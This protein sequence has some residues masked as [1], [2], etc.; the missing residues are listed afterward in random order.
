MSK[1][2]TFGQSQKKA[3]PVSRSG[4]GT[5]GSDGSELDLLAGLAPLLELRDGGEQ[6]IGR[7]VDGSLER[8]LNDA[9]DETD[10]DDLHGDVVGDAEQGAGHG[11]EQQ[12]AARNAGRAARAERRHDRQDDRDGQLHGDAERVHRGERHDRDRD[13]SAG[14]VDGRAE[15]DGHGVELLIQTEALAQGHIHGDVRGGRARE[16]S[17]HAA[18]LEAF[19]HQRIGVLAHGGKGHDGVD[20]E[21]REQHAAH[22]QEQQLAVLG[23]DGQTARGHGREHETEDAE[24]GEIDDEAHRLRDGLGGVGEEALGRIR[25]A[26]ERK[27][28]HDGPEQDTEEVAADDRADGVGDDVGQQVREDLR[29]G[30]GRAV[31][32]GLGQRDG[33]GEEVACSHGDDGREKRGHEVEHDDGA[34]LLA[35]LLLGLGE[36]ADDEHEHEQ[37]GDRFERADEQFAE[38]ADAGSGHGGVGDQQGERRADG[39]ADDDAQ[40]EADAVVGFDEFHFF[41]L[42]FPFAVFASESL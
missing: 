19:E 42:L 26:L 10:A 21:R 2:I 5:Y 41:L 8:V 32:S 24:G 4:F 17:G 7:G 39:H 14:H 9:D 33:H 40:H 12:R 15:R 37:R 35:H 34:K 18:L 38:D 6:R 1:S 11:D 36:R 25:S 23:E 29:E 27:A 20:D 30:L 16:E 3:R 13:G 28:E 22:E 31:G